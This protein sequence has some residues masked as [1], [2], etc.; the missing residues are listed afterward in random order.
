ML[1]TF[2]LETKRE[3]K[4]WGK[5]E[6]KRKPRN[7]FFK[8]F[9]SI[10]TKQTNLLIQCIPRQRGRK[11]KRHGYY[12]Y[13]I[14]DVYRIQSESCNQKDIIFFP[15]SVLSKKINVLCLYP[16]FTCS[17]THIYFSFLSIVIPSVKCYKIHK[18]MAVF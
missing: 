12:W 2:N 4:I 3:R 17:S 8:I 1:F 6:R 7:I 10:R 14:R 11:H 9:Y 16:L 18:W 13:F 5:V 15:L